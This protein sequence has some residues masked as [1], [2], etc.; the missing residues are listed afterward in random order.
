MKTPRWLSKCLSYVR[1]EWDRSKRYRHLP[2]LRRI[3]QAQ[4]AEKRKHRRYK[5]FDKA[6]EALMTSALERRA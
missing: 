4:A 1:S 2:E 5:H 3:D 6:R